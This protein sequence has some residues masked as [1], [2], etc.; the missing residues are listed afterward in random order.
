MVQ[1]IQ[2]NVGALIN[3]TVGVLAAVR[4]IDGADTIASVIMGTGKPSQCLG[5]STSSPTLGPCVLLQ[6]LGRRHGVSHNPTV[7]EVEGDMADLFCSTGTNACYMEQLGN[8]TK[9]LPHYRPRTP[10]MVVNIE[11]PGFQVPYC[12]LHQPDS[13]NIL[14]LHGTTLPA[15]QC[16][17]CLA[18]CKGPALM[19]CH[20]SLSILSEDVRLESCAYACRQQSFRCLMRTGS[21][22]QTPPTLAS[23]SL[24]S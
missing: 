9:W 22:M 7:T 6:A 21:W 24:R 16:M 18:C 17:D 8:I 13:E 4:Y 11:W 20:S 2:A 15:S 1:G 5:G 10:D 3:D 14:C 23:S 12:A 19:Q